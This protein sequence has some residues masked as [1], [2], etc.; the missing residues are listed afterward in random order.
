MLIHEMDKHQ[1]EF[2]Q[3]HLNLALNKINSQQ[4]EIASMR[5]SHQKVLDT[6]GALEEK[7]DGL[8][9]KDTHIWVIP[10]FTETL[11][12]AKEEGNGLI[13]EESF[14]T[15]QGYKLRFS[16][17]YKPENDGDVS[18]YAYMAEG[19]FDKSLNWPLKATI[20]F[21]VD[22]LDK[23]DKFPTLGF[24][25]FTKPPH[26]FGGRGYQWFLKRDEI[27]NC[28]VNGTLTIVLKTSPL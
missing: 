14:Y 4:E 23:H 20:E 28:H 13:I 24:E 7:V 21:L 2:A 11:Q 22:K 25:Q 15:S 6:L 3:F 10:K 9:L 16:L 8:P 27:P 19:V 12:T 18:L 1:S 17:Q 26:N 5:D